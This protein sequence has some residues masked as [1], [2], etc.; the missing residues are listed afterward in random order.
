[1]A[2]TVRLYEDAQ[3]FSAAAEAFLLQRPVLHNL[4]LTIIDNRITH[5]EPGRYWVALHGDQVVGAALQ[6]PLTFPAT[7]VP[8]QPEA[9]A[10]IVDAITDAGIILPGVNGEAATAATFA[11]H[12]TERHKSTAHPTQGIRLYELLKLNEIPAVDGHLR[13]A[14]ASDRDQ[15]VS[16]MQ[17]FYA[18][19][20]ALASNPETLIDNAIQSRRLWIWQQGT[21]V[22]M[23]T[24]SQPIHNVVR[25]SAVYTPPAHR[26][27]GYAGACVHALSSNL[28]D[29][30]H[31]CIL[32]TDLGNP[33]SNSI[34]RKIGYQAVSEAL[35]YRFDPL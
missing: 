35:H 24:A 14:E 26:A 12:W 4:I 30:G 19:T 34:Y 10:A 7:I 3:S 18:E 17:A 2:I 11:G 31:R 32:Y 27:R 29:A 28:T 33:T 22:S 20:H 9:A 6:S 1:M 5:P 23:A 13:E 8:M 15:A 21:T 16:W 25:I